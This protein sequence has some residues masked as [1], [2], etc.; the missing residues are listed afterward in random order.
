MCT[1]EEFLEGHIEMLVHL[2]CLCV[3]DSM[4]V[5]ALVCGS[6]VAPL[7]LPIAAP[8][9]PGQGSPFFTI[10]TPQKSCVSC[11]MTSNYFCSSVSFII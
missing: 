2:E 10:E 5:S 3:H 6:A 4:L 11:V 1:L 9:G 8:C 7:K